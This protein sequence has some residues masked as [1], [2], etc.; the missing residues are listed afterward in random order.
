MKPKGNA[1]FNIIIITITA[2]LVGVIGVLT[3]MTINKGDTDIKKQLALGEKYISEGDFDEAIE[4]FK[5]VI[6]IDPKC[7]DAYIGIA[8]AYASLENYD[9]AIEYLNVVSE[10]SESSAVKLEV[11][12][13]KTEYEELKRIKESTET[14]SNEAN[15]SSGN[16]GSGESGQPGSD[17]PEQT[18]SE[19]P[20]QQVPEE[21]P[22]HNYAWKEV[23][24][25]GLKHPDGN[26]SI[27]EVDLVL[28][29][30]GKTYSVRLMNNCMIH[31]PSE[32]DCAY[33]IYDVWCDDT[34][35]DVGDTTSI[36][37]EDG[38]TILTVSTFCDDVE[39]ILDISI[40]EEVDVTSMQI[41]PIPAMSEYEAYSSR[42]EGVF[43][44][45]G[46]Y[47]D[48][49]FYSGDLRDF[50]VYYQGPGT[51]VVEIGIDWA[52]ERFFP[53]GPQ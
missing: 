1:K 27:P 15:P 40:I 46:Y 23:R 43:I 33:L 50:M 28:T 42:V 26:E 25:N 20:E 48:D 5:K 13:L 41:A 21:E 51:Y 49:E 45:A 19:E 36:E 30:K 52:N 11:Q 24:V 9:A 18:G 53:N 47:P 38:I 32:P 22:E 4:V 35:M 8:N 10:F 14:S 3:Y 34:F 17:E 44:S 29:Y 39:D 6:S 31:N 12:E 7:E 37:A 2:I 16:G